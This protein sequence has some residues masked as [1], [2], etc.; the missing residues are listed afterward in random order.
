[1]SEYFYNINC[2]TKVLSLPPTTKPL[3]QAKADILSLLGF[4]RLEELNK[5]TSFEK[6]NFSLLTE[7]VT[8]EIAV[9]RTVVIRFI[10]DN[11]EK[12]GNYPIARFNSQSAMKESFVRNNQGEVDQIRTTEGIFINIKS[13]NEIQVFSSISS[14]KRSMSNFDNYQSRQVNLGGGFRLQAN[15]VRRENE[16][17]FCDFSATIVFDDEP[18]RATQLNNLAIP[19]VTIEFTAKYQNGYFVPTYSL[20]RLEQIIAQSDVRFFADYLL[21]KIIEKDGKALA[22]LFGALFQVDPSLQTH[23]VE[24]VFRTVQEE[25]SRL[26]LLTEVFDFDG[27]DT[28][29][30]WLREKGRI[31]NKLS[32][33]VS[34]YLNRTWDPVAWW[35][36]RETGSL[37]ISYCERLSNTSDIS[38]EIRKSICNHFVS[39]E[40]RNGEVQQLITLTKELTLPLA[41]SRLAQF[42]RPLDWQM[43]TSELFEI[44]CKNG[45]TLFKF[46]IENIDFIYWFE[47]GYFVLPKMTYADM[48]TWIKRNAKRIF[49]AEILSVHLHSLREG[50]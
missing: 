30:L 25:N 32:S 40:L 37:F 38:E 49:E 13:I 17:A 28:R 43:H 45:I 7:F 34:G 2:L 19:R 33:F 46:T 16:E 12:G 11:G 29:S 20:R 10:D 1:M 47:E 39:I 24:G 18:S 23:S 22:V 26:K 21:N 3:K 42:F 5:Q 14:L 44:F 27:T 9:G 36:A 15:T 31:Y 41:L 50:D 8:R 4:S 48:M 6:G 35:Q